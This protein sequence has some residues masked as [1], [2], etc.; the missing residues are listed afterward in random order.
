MRVFLQLSLHQE[1]GEKLFDDVDRFL[2]LAAKHGH[3]V[4]PVLQPSSILNPNYKPQPGEAEEPETESFRPGVHGSYRRGRRR[5]NMLSTRQ[6]FEQAKAPAKAFVEAMLKRYGR[7][8][9]IVAWDLFNEPIPPDRAMVEHMFACAREAGA[10]QP[11]TATW[12][13]ED[14]S[15]IYSFHTYGQPGNA[16]GG[17]PELLPFDVELKQAIDSGRPLVCTECLARTFGNTFEAFLPYFAK[18]KVG[19]YIWGALRGVGAAPL[20]VALADRVAG[21]E[22]LVSLHTLSG[23][24]AVPGPRN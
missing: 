8:E 10:S 17:E 22:E 13:G 7:D 6:N 9:R 15:D 2:A 12:Q 3:S 19:W 1:R 18:H 24:H 20:S 5:R 11:L 16:K 4:M 23:R 21:A 14:L